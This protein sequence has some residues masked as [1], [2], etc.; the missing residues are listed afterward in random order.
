M[1]A[2]L[3]RCLNCGREDTKG[4]SRLN[5]RRIRFENGQMTQRPSPAT[6]VCRPGYGC[7]GVGTLYVAVLCDPAQREARGRPGSER[8]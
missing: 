2:Y 1:D 5:T 7:E 6:W 3:K 4:F 8:A